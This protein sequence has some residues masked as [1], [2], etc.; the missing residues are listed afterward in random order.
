MARLALRLAAARLQVRGCSACLARE[1]A[2]LDIKAT[3]H[4][5]RH[6][7]ASNAARRS[8]LHNVKDLLG[9]QSIESTEIYLH[10]L[11]EDLQAAVAF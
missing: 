4:T 10:S 11:P 8:S 1:R 7:F 3:P 6:T 9:H 2:N 5:L